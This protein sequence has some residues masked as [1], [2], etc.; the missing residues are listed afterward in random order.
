MK[1][2][3]L[4]KGK[5]ALVDDDDFDELSKHKWCVSK[6]G[7]NFYAIRSIKIDGKKRTV[8]MHRVIMQTPKG[9]DTDH[10]DHDGLDNRKENLRI[11]TH[12][13]NLMNTGKYKNNVSGYKGVSWDNSR[14]K[15]KSQIKFNKKIIILG[16]FTDKEEAYKAYCEAAKKYHGEFNNL[17]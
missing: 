15:W 2:I 9:M 13:E 8:K 12:T 10:I 11:C 4:T 3:E 1:K 16:R 14:S 17:L 7:N 6:D 5:V